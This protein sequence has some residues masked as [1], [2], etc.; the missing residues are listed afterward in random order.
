MNTKMCECGSMTD[1]KCQCAFFDGE[2]WTDFDHE[3]LK[4][5]L[6]EEWEDDVDWGEE[7]EAPLHDTEPA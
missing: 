4:E 6:E 2:P 5:L 3:D 1:E 7:G